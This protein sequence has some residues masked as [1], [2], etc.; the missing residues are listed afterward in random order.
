[1]L[2]ALP[3]FAR[4]VKLATWDA[5]LT[6]GGPGYLLRDLGK[7]DEPQTSAA[8]QVLAALGADVVVLTGMDYDLSGQ[9]LAALQARLVAAGADYPFALAL[10]PNS[11]VPTGL[12]LDHDGIL[13]NP[14]DAQGYGRFPGQA[15]IAVLSRLPLQAEAMQDF[16]GYLW[17]DLPGA[18]LPPDMTDEARAVQR[19]ATTGFYDLP[20][21][22]GGTVM[23]LFLYAATPPVFDGPEDR[24]G[25][26]NADETGFWLHLLQGEM[27]LAVPRTGFVV[28]GL[29]NLDPQDGDGKPASLRAL[30]ASPLVQD[31]GPRG[32]SGHTDRGAQG[33][34]GLDTW[35]SKSGWGLRLDY[36]LPSADLN[37]TGAGVLWPAPS[38]PLAAVLEAASDHRPVWV[39]IEVP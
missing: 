20:V 14:R 15:G 10:R 6:R 30:L 34:P 7:T 23:H 26:R 31:P 28:M 18:D 25:R 38:D 27:A 9:A 2:L 36:V 24:N 3:A 35:I 39:T 11:G 8:V 13:N 21:Q 5:G 33:D 4:E 37:V 1:M 16:S 12:D 19:L 29:A 22:V 17:A 32:S